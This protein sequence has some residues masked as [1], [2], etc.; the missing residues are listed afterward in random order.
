MDLICNRINNTK[1]IEFC[2]FNNTKC[3]AI[4]P[5]L[6]PWKFVFGDYIFELSAPALLRE[7]YDDEKKVY[8][9]SLH[10]RGSKDSGKNK[11]KNRY[12]MGNV[13]LKNFYS[14]YDY[15]A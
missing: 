9:C 4:E 15:D 11:R 8:V 2:Y 12:L 13:F 6:E 10:V 5:K 7:D 1:Q 3:E 14:V